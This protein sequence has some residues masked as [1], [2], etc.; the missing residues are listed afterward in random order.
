MHALDCP[1]SPRVAKAHT[2]RRARAERYDLLGASSLD[3]G[4]EMRAPRSGGERPEPGRRT[5]NARRRT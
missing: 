3:R 5:R 1:Y 2:V 4:R